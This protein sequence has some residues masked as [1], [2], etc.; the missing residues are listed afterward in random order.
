MTY[1]PYCSGYGKDLYFLLNMLRV[2]LK[3]SNS[4][5]K[6]KST[7]FKVTWYKCNE[8]TAEGKMLAMN[9]SGY[10]SVHTHRLLDLTNTLYFTTQVL[11][12]SHGAND[13]I[14]TA[15]LPGSW[16]RWTPSAQP[17]SLQLSLPHSCNALEFPQSLADLGKLPPK[18]PSSPTAAPHPWEAPGTTAHSSLHCGDH[19]NPKGDSSSGYQ[20]ALS[21]QVV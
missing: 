13:S 10:K 8:W 5:S 18:L 9:W 2:T 16:W 21:L 19:T 4:R 1:R 20:A 12:S 17:E 11:F 3:I 6:L 14:S 15:V 7:Y